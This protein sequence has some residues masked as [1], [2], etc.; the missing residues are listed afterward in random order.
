MNIENIIITVFIFF[1]NLKKEIDK[2]LD[3][4][5]EAF[6][7]TPKTIEKL[8]NQITDYFKLLFI[9]FK[10]VN[11]LAAK[12]NNNPAPNPINEKKNKYSEKASEFIGKEISHLKKDKGYPQDRAVA[13]AINVAKDKGMK[14]GSKKPKA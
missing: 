10:K 4:I 11:E 3:T 13:A 2:N 8:K 9:L 12:E 1:K 14:V 7:P 5:L 6:K